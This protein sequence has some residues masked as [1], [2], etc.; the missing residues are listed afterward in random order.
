[1]DGNGRILLTPPLRDYAGLEKKAVLLGQG[2]KLELWSEEVW[3][4]RRD[5]WLDDE[6][7][8]EVPDELLNISL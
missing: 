1:M 7:G 6:S 4:S 2:G 5:A 3:L 8:V